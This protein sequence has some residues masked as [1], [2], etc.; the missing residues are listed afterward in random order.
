MI[1]VSINLIKNTKKIN[2]CKKNKEH[3]SAEKLIEKYAGDIISSSGMQ[4]E[5]NFMQHGGDV[6]KRQP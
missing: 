1:P 3:L 6:Y 5:K 4:S 2:T